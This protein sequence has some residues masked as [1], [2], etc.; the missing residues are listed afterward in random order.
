MTDG[1]DEGAARARWLAEVGAA[2]DEAQRLTRRLAH[3]HSSSTE[4]VILRIQIMAA[5][6][7]VEALQRARNAPEWSK[8]AR[9]RPDHKP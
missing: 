4:A 2:L 6:A 7:E 8:R 5:R 1:V 9:P 3:W